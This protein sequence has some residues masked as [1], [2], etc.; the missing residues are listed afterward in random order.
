LLDDTAAVE[1]LF[2]VPEINSVVP[3]GVAFQNDPVLDVGVMN[4]VY[5]LLRG[6]EGRNF[7]MEKLLS[8]TGIITSDDDRDGY[9][10]SRAYYRSGIVR[11]YAYDINHDSVFDLRILFSADGVPVSAKIPVTG[12]SPAEIQW[13]RYPSVRQITLPARTPYLQETFLFRPADFQYMPVNLVIFGG[14]NKYAGPAYPVLM[15]QYLETTRRALVSFCFGI[16]RPSA[17][18]E[19]A[20]EEIFLENGVLLRAVETINEKQVS[21][22]EFERGAPVIQRLDMD[23]DGRMETIRRFHRADRFG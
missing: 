13:E 17:E 9:I 20:T 2:S 19:D 8:F 1:E 3:Q 10:D 21:V 7:F 6:D 4:D 22:T 12:N 23:L 14:S 16:K 15:P 5:G 18:F 11:E